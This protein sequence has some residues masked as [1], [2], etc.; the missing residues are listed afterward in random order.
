M[1]ICSGAGTLK[2]ESK[3]LFLLQGW[4]LDSLAAGL[5]ATMTILKLAVLR[6]E[7]Q[8]EVPQGGKR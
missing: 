5:T 1:E 2:H 4:M 7:V 3:S 8:K 6:I